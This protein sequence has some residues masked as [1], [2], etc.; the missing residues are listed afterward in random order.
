MH[1]YTTDYAT[2]LCSSGSNSM[3]AA[4]MDRH[5]STFKCLIILAISVFICTIA[6]SPLPIH[7]IRC[8]HWHDLQLFKLPLP[9]AFLCWRYHCHQRQCSIF[10]C[11]PAQENNRPLEVPSSPLRSRYV[12]KSKLADAFVMMGML[13]II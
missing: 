13:E 11:C 5:N 1:S 6:P 3:N 9:P 7:L 12:H 4:C 8:C 10:C 2:Y